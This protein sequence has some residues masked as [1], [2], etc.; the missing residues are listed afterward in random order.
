MLQ[1]GFDPLLE[2]PA[3]LFVQLMLQA[4]E[5]LEVRGGGVLGHVV[6]GAMVRREEVLDVAQAFRDHIEHGAVRRGRHVLIESRDA[7]IGRG[8]DGARIRRLFP[9]EDLEERG[10][11]GAVSSDDRD[12]LPRFDLQIDVVEQGKMPEGQRQMREGD[13]GLGSHSKARLVEGRAASSP[14]RTRTRAEGASARCRPCR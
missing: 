5:V 3:V 11:P 1:D 10:L 8:P 7:E 2:P 13:H 12:T 9:A 6:G 4:S 14:A